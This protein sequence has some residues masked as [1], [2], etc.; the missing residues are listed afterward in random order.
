MVTDIQHKLQ[1]HG[2]HGKVLQPVLQLTRCMLSSI[3]IL[4]IAFDLQLFPLED[5]PTVL[6][7]NQLQNMAL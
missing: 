3:N 5:F 2:C 4:M 6:V 1:H 7:L